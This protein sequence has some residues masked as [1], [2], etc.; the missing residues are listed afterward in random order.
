MKSHHDNEFI[1]HLLDLMTDLGA[2]Q[3]RRMFGGHGIYRGSKMFG[4]VS[5]DVLYLKVDDGNR[6]D[7]EEQDLE[8]FT[9][10][11]KHKPMQMSYCRA[12]DDALENREVMLIWARKAYEAAVRS[13]TPKKKTA[14]KK[15]TAR[16][17]SKKKA[18]RKKSAAAPKKKPAR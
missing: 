12:P 8:P 7:F 16:K 13:G 17:A 9:Y 6:A 3:A 14:A 10:Q 2:V 11:G 18:A 4:L 5:G 15:K 1:D